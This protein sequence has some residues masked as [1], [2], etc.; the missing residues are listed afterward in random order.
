[1]QKN[2][3]GREGACEESEG[4]LM[5]GQGKAPWVEAVMLEG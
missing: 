4:G 2:S 3:D 5:G 1:M